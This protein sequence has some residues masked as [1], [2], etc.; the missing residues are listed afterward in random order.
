MRATALMR[1]AAAMLFAFALMCTPSVAP[2]NCERADRQHGGAAF[3]APLAGDWRFSGEANGQRLDGHANGV[4][5][6][7]VLKLV[8]RPTDKGTRA[9]IA[10]LSL[11][12]DTHCDDFVGVR[13]EWG[14]DGQLRR[15]EGRGVARGSGLDVTFPA[16]S[17]GHRT[18]IALERDAAHAKWLVQMNRE[19]AE[20]RWVQYGVLRLERAGSPKP[21]GSRQ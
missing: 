1:L 9:G 10:S 12:Y 19:L 5:E 18:D 13:D 2:A 15:S 20:G 7:G 17:D 8:F 6:G 3:L 21:S 16:Q 4:L 14:A 11:R